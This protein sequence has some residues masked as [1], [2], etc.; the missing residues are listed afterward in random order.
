[1]VGF[2]AGVGVVA[3]GM[4]PLTTAPPAHADF[5]DLVIEPI[6]DLFGLDNLIDSGLSSDPGLDFDESSVTAAAAAA[7]DSQLQ[8]SV[9][10]H[11]EL[12]TEPVVELSANGGPETSVLVDTGSNGLV[13]PIW[14]LGLENLTW[15]TGIEIGSYSGGLN[16]FALEFPADIE[17]EGGLSTVEPA[18]I[19]A[20]LFTYPDSLADLFSYPTSIEEAL[21]GAAEGVLGIGPNAS[22]P[23][24][25]SVLEA[26]PGALGEGVLID[27]P[28]GQLVFGPN[29]ITD[30]TAVDG[31]PL[32]EV[33]VSING[34]PPELV[35][36]NIDSGGV[37]GTMPSS[38]VGDAAVSGGH[39]E[40][41]TVVSVYT[42]DHEPLYSY[43]VNDGSASPTVTSGDVMNTGNFPFSQGE[44]YIDGDGNGTTV[45]GH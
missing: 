36:A 44:I 6:L 15:P 30:G 21:G 27:Q 11:M 3:L 34:G 28:D 41:G 43:F 14:D 42:T 12:G 13:I 39:L 10:L 38:V 16:Y 26:L 1:M 2:I 32:S 45:F 5:E 4:T 29:P 8:A 23:D 9:P 7:A 37:Y 31:A 19:N 40:E 18:S 17:F 24:T 20:V 25:D 22:G 35:T 33:L